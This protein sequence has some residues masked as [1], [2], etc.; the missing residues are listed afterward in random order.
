MAKGILR[1]TAVSVAK[2]ILDKSLSLKERQ[3]SWTVYFSKQTL[4]HFSGYLLSDPGPQIVH[5]LSSNSKQ[6]LGGSSLLK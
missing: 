3:Y 1:K 5:F 6:G 4:N 2:L